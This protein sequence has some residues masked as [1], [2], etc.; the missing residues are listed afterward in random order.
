MS[1]EQPRTHLDLFSGIGSWAI[2]AEWAGYRS[3]GFAESADYPSAVLQ[4]HWPHIKNYG[5]VRKV[6]AKKT[7]R[8][9]LITASPP[10]QPYS[11]AT[12]GRRV[13]C[14]DRILWP[15][16]FSVIEDIRPTWFI[17][18]EV[19]DFAQMG[20][21]DFFDAMESISY[22]T[23]AVCIP[24]GAIGGLHRRER[25]WFLAHTDEPRLEGY[26]KHRQRPRK[27][28]AWSSLPTHL[29]TES[30]SRIFRM[31]DGYS[32]WPHR[33]ART[34]AVGNTICPQVAYE[35]LKHL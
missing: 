24:V 10:C 33:I 17:G 18:E 16:L 21:D 31:V 20:L 34:Q 8:C 5:D 6:T 35:I 22:Q 3:I 19:A 27:R 23:A 29:W 14:D 12:G 7:G 13:E 4:R 30:G 28:T 32:S 11:K 1:D 9:D 26:R 25:L 15:E 2:A